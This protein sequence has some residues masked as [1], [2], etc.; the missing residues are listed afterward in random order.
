MTIKK[1]L[2]IKQPEVGQIIHDLRLASGL[3]QEQLAA[4][5]GVT[6]STINRWE[7]G[8]SKPSPM[9]MKLIEQK[10]DEMGTQGQ[11]LLAKYLQN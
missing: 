6:Y 8:R 5:L 4:Q 1:P 2:A 3:T 9:A 11:D 10:L 7:N